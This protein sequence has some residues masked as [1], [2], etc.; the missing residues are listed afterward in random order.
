MIAGAVIVS[1][2]L[3]SVLIRKVA[4]QSAD[5]TELFSFDVQTYI[6][7]NKTIF[8]TLSRAKSIDT[9]ADIAIQKAAL[10]RHKEWH[11]IFRESVQ[12]AHQETELYWYQGI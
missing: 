1:S 11:F 2:V 3:L 4:R 7:L 6:L 10:W 8:L 9:C 5:S 12:A